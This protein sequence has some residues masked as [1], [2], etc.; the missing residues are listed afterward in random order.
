MNMSD[1]EEDRRTPIFQVPMLPNRYDAVLAACSTHYLMRAS[2]GK[3]LYIS[4]EPI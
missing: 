2:T 1:D 4:P 3:E